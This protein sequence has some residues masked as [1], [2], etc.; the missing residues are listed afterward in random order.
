MGSEGL[1]AH[2]L[3]EQ[4]EVLSLV[5]NIALKEGKADATAHG[6]HLLEA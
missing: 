5:G 2:R 1:Q 4:L 3:K 6:G